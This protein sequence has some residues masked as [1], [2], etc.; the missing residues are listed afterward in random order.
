MAPHAPQHDTATIRRRRRL[1]NTW[2]L[3]VVAWSLVRTAIVW[4]AVG[5][6][7]LNPWLYLVLDL[8]SASVD[9]VSTPRMVIRFV[10]DQYR[11]ALQWAA[12]SLAAFVLPDV[13]IFLG[14]RTLPTKLIVLILSI[15]FAT[16]VVAV[17]MVIRKIQKARALQ[18]SL[19]AD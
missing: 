3:L 1:S 17:V 15:I 9:A 11:K 18:R 12:V 7:G 13:Y 19:Q 14:T 10:D 8:I 5:D 6:Y 2:A 16:L 4:A